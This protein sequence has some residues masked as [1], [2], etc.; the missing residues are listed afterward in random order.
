MTIFSIVIIKSGII[1]LLKKGVKLMQKK[2]LLMFVAS[3]IVTSLH[4]ARTVSIP[5]HYMT[6]KAPAAPIETLTPAEEKALEVKH[7]FINDIKNYLNKTLGSKG[8]PI[9]S[10][11]FNR[12]IINISALKTHKAAGVQLIGTASQ[13]LYSKVKQGFDM[14]M[15]TK[16]HMLGGSYNLA[17]G[18]IDKAIGLIAEYY[19]KHTSGMAPVEPVVT[20][21]TTTTRPTRR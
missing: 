15:G 8:L 16:G 11:D 4:A 10:D 2:L 6:S 9:P 1:I 12:L 3:I 14:I 7:R 19:V 20:H 18:F 13:A 21:P 17:E 5:S